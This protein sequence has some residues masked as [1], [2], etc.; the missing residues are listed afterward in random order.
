MIIEYEPKV[1][2]KFKK[3][4]VPNIQKIQFGNTDCHDHQP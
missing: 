4:L 2:E 1:F 3:A